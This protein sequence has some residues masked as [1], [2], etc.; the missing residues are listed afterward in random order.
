MYSLERFKEKYLE[1]NFDNYLLEENNQ[2]V[3]SNEHYLELKN[4]YFIKTRE[5]FNRFK[6][7]LEIYGSYK[8]NYKINEEGSEHIFI[9][10]DQ[11]KKKNINKELKDIIL[12]QN[13]NLDC[14][15]SRIK[16]LNEKLK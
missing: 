10:M 14:L 5:N 8:N 1:V 15:M 6:A 16:L 12:D 4:D 11:S 7:L 3:N 9:Y 13:R 2:Y